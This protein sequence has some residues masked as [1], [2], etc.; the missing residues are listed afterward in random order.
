MSSNTH[1]KTRP[2][3]STSKQKVNGIHT[4]KYKIRIRV[5]QSID[6]RA[7]P[8]GWI[9]NRLA[10]NSL[11]NT[12][13]CLLRK[14]LRRGTNYWSRNRNSEIYGGTQYHGPRNRPHRTMAQNILAQGRMLWVLLIYKSRSL[15]G[16]DP[17]VHQHH[18]LGQNVLGTILV[19]IVVYPWIGYN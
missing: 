2:V 5:T 6:L 18:T 12:T 13:P 9:I 16:R 15:L 10:T 3:A 19:L 4:D 14:V 7:V 11:K 17:H 1:T 8:S